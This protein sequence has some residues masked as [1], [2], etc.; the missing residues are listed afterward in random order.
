M[1]AEIITIGDEILIGQIVDTNSAWIGQQ[2]NAVGFKV[3]Q[4]TSV[5]DNREHILAA[6]K[7]AAGRVQVVLI[8]G[9][10]GPTKD[11]ITKKTICDYFNVGLR[12]DE[13]AYKDVEHLFK[14]RG[15]EVT[16]INRLQAEVPVNCITMYNRVGTAPGMWFDEG[17]VIYASM[18]GVPHEMKYLMEKEVLPRL[19]ER[20]ET[21]F[22]LHKTL[23]TQGIGESFL[24][25]MISGFEDVLP[26]NFKLAY[27]PSAGAV[28]L[29]LTASG[30]REEVTNTMNKLVAELSDLVREYLYGYDEDTIQEVVGRLLKDKKLTLGTAES[31][32]GGYLSHLITSIP[33]SSEYYMGSTVTYS[34]ESKTALLDVPADLV[35][36]FGA[37][38]EEVVKAMAEGAKKKFNAD[39]ALATS[40]IAGPG[41]GSPE[42]P[43]GTVWIGIST[44]A[45][46]KA[47]KVLLGDNRLRTIEVASMTALNMLRKELSGNA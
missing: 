21:P 35:I 44:P 19:K 29:R 11:D 30:N 2:M 32:T 46:T 15:R 8:T 14:I 7:E 26:A 24:S 13:E 22:I 20:F 45:G 37:V 31:C 10:L 6:L 17:G 3:H 47:K 41:G 42:K 9:G 1:L 23:L 27:L 33:G 38:S 25:E 4:I 36:K 16:P 28:R 12:F 5:S 39:C 34:N 40:G 43:V 18:P